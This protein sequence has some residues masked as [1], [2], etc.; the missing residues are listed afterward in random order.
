MARPLGSK[1]VRVIATGAEGLRFNHSGSP[2]R[3][4]NCL[5]AGES[6]ELLSEVCEF[7]SQY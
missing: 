4:L 3:V 5:Q 7:A 6:E 1:V 2:S